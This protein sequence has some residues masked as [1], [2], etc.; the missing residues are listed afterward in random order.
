M[1]MSLIA[2]AVVAGCIGLLLVSTLN[3]QRPGGAPSRSGAALIDV[4]AIA[5]NST[6][7]KQQLEGL[8]AELEA[9]AAEFKKESDQGNA[10]TEKLRKMP[11]NT[12]ERKKLEEQLLKMRADFELR[13]KRVDQ[14]AHEKESKLIYAMSRELHEELARYAQANGIQLI[15]QHNTA[16]RE[17]IDRQAIVQ[18][19]QKPVIYQRD[20]DITPMILEAMNR[21]GPAPGAAAKAPAQ[22]KGVQR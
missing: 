12:P 22:S 9:K 4:G 1:R 8:K 16:P 5:Q 19:I 6:K 13:G 14:E 15:L 20:S 17:L 21:R 7:L 18:E 3:A 11:P 10:L 2:Q